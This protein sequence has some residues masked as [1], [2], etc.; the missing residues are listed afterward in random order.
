LSADKPTPKFIKQLVRRRMAATGEK[1][2]TALR[3]VKTDVEAA[4]AQYGK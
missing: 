4:R 1:Y 3:A 2:T